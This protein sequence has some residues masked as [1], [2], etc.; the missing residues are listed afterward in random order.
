MNIKTHSKLYMAGVSLLALA[1]S[2]PA[3]AQDGGLDEV[4]VTATKRAENAQD[5]GV[6]VNAFNEEAM[7]RGGIQD[8]SRL[9]LTTPGLSFAQ[10]GN[11]FKPTIRG[12]NSEN[13][14]RDNSPP[15]GL[16][17]DG[18]YKPTA[19]QQ[20][21]AFLDVQR[22][23]V[24][25]GPQGT[26]FGRNTLGGAFNIITNKPDLDGVSFGV[27]NT[28]G[29]YSAVKVDGYLNVP[30]SDTFGVRLAAAKN[31]ADGY[32]ENLGVGEDLGELNDLSLRL[33]ALWEPNDDFSALLTAYSYDSEG[34]SLGA[35]G[36][37]SRGTLRDAVTG[38]TDNDGVFDPVNP[39]AGSL[40]ARADRGPWE[41]YRD[42]EYAR[43]LDEK[44]VSL[45]LNYDMGPVSFKSL[46]SYT[47]FT[48]FAQADADYSENPFQIE[49]YTEFME[50]WTQEFQ[51]TSNNDSALKWVA[52][53]YFSDE[54]YD[55]TYF[56]FA[57]N[58]EISNAGLRLPDNGGCAGQAFATAPDP[59]TP[60]CPSFRGNG[61]PSNKT[62]GAFAQGT[63][64]FTDALRLTAGVRY[65]QD[66]K[67]FST[68]NDLVGS[69]PE[70][71]QTFDDVTW[72]VGVEAD[73]LE[74]SLLYATAS[75]GFLAGGFNSN[76]TTFNQ[77][78]V[79]A[80]EIGM[81]NR[82]FDDTVQLNVAA[83]YNDFK[84][85]L[86]GKLITD[87]ATGAVITVQDNGGA[88]EAKGVE[89]DLQAAPTDR[90]NLTATLTWQDSKYG[91]F[92]LA[93]RFNQ[94][95]NTPASAGNTLQ[96]KGLTTPWAPTWSASFSGGYEIPTSIGSFTP[97]VQ[98]SYS[99]SHFTTGLQ[100]FDLAEQDAYVKTDLR[101]FYQPENDNWTASAFVENVSNEAILH[102]TIIGGNDIVQVSWSK[103]RM[104]GVK[105]GYKY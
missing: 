85:L 91:D 88:I 64:S 37:Q 33:S 1:V 59:G 105:F 90:L 75:T 49:S 68:I 44:V 94:G 81:K 62:F 40:G 58:G 61:K 19:S 70:E 47:D 11:D 57:L 36:Y 54:E 3:A 99:G 80:Y 6:T 78:E 72:R 96:L 77:Q 93:N 69:V 71:K 25:K 66:K 14:F 89:F 52:G 39:R 26:L 103:P 102:H 30:L 2:V 73:V 76:R 9:E 18:V 60:V 32:I 79:Q 97:F 21:G 42:S 48:N 23:E 10:R 46:S 101:L 51:V 43:E 28:L 16:F 24:L 4:I 22:V 86:A 12:A 55:Q 7:E 95:S 74:D 98:L 92:L 27:E 38:I 17:V 45:E 15:I 65:S 20:S 41:V 87:A 100:Q 34:S 67:T 84:D 8:I 29:N 5:I 104:Y 35:F 83:Y 82:F 31:K 56:K 63:Y 53:L 13:T 50:A